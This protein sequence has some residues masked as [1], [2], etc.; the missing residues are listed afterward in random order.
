MIKLVSGWTRPGGGT[1]ANIA[2]TNLLNENGV[3]CIFYGPDEWHLDKCKGGLL[4]DALFY[5]EDTVISH[6]IQVPAGLACKNHILY[7]HEKD[8]FPLNKVD[9]K[10]Y[11]TI[12]FV[13]NEQKKWHGVTHP[14]VIIPPIVETL[15]WKNPHNGVA[16]VV[17][18]VDENKQ[19]HMSVQRA[20]TDGYAK[21]KLFGEGNDRLYF[22]ESVRPLLDAQAE[23]IL[24]G[25]Q[26]NREA[27][28]GQ[29]EVVYHSSRSETFGLVEA[30]CSLAGIPFNGPSNNPAIV[31][32][33]E[34]YRRWKKL[35]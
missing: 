3:E 34:I 4:K 31:D 8:L 18:S 25:H 2:L 12:V 23:V 13:S 30:E 15:K 17:G 16:G 10:K 14:S 11:N 35:F 19:T 24:E 28:Y 5:E 33:K 7:C 20:I 22:D 1:I 6:F 32:K 27:M 26:D 9:Y 21:I 29:V